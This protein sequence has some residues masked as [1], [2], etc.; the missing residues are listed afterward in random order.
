M[1][2]TMS[3]LVRSG[4]ISL[5][6]TGLAQR[7]YAFPNLSPSSATT[8]VSAKTGHL[9][10]YSQSCMNWFILTENEKVSFIKSVGVTCEV[11]IFVLLGN[12][13]PGTMNPM[14]K[15][16]SIQPSSS[17]ISASQS[18]TGGIGN[19]F[20]SHFSFATPPGDHKQSWS[21][22]SK[23]IEMSTVPS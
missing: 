17:T 16:S 9:E 20:S 1:A 3:H 15:Q 7:R 13:S 19:L 23:M 14:S 2:N 6:A 10:T 12:R 4:L 22:W 5:I 8:V 18:V 21:R 11:L